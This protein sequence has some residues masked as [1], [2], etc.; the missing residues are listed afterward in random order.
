MRMVSKNTSAT[1][2]LTKISLFHCHAKS[3]APTFTDST[4]A[5]EQ[6]EP[7][8]EDLENVFDWRDRLKMLDYSESERK[9]NEKRDR[10]ENSD[11]SVVSVRTD[12]EGGKQVEWCRAEARGNDLKG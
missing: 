1:S 8:S 5:H 11:S 2:G 4:Q 12:E 3:T 10:A 6:T 7:Q 9:K